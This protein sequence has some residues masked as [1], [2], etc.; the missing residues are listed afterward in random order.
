MPKVLKVE[1]RLLL[2]DNNHIKCSYLFTKKKQ[3]CI[4]ATI[5]CI[6]I[7]ELLIDFI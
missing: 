3:R 2:N 6:Y 7:Y 1:S 4:I 5:N